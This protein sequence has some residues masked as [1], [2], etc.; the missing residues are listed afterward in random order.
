MLGLTFR[1]PSRNAHRC[2]QSWTR[3]DVWPRRRASSLY[4]S[5]VGRRSTRRSIRN[6]GL[7]RNSRIFQPIATNVAGVHFAPPAGRPHRR[8]TRDRAVVRHRRSDHQSGGYWVNT[9]YRYPAPTC[10]SLSADWPTVG[11]IVKLLRPSQAVPFSTVALPSNCRQSECDPA[12]TQWR[13]PRPAGTSLQGNPSA[14]NFRVEGLASPAEVPT[15]RLSARRDL[16]GQLDRARQLSS[17][18]PRLTMRC[19][20]CVLYWLS[21]SCSCAGCSETN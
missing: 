21:R 7:R 4:F 12:G 20:C 15:I 2:S 9:G 8:Q 14:D 17:E 3:T 5:P 10:G 18:H 1:A 13:I 19:S 16:L 6:P 11:S